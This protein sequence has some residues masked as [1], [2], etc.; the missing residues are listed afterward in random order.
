MSS[1]EKA[2][3]KMSSLFFFFFFFSSLNV[4][5]FDPDSSMLEFVRYT[6]FVIIIIIIIIII[7]MSCVICERFRNDYARLLT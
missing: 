3:Y 4:Y 1:H 2:L 7:I 6:N 5:T